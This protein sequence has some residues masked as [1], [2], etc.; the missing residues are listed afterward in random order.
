MNIDGTDL[1]FI[2]ALVSTVII[3]CVGL[4]NAVDLEI[5]EMKL[6]AIKIQHEV[7]K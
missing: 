6:E 7:A 5:A 4:N 1:V 2:T 3:A